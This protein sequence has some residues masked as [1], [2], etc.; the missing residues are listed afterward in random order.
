M[1]DLS[2]KRKALR[3][4]VSSRDGVEVGGFRGDLSLRG[5]LDNAAQAIQNRLLTRKGEI[6]KLGHH[7]YGSELF[8]LIGEPLSWKTQ[9][10][11]ELYVREA[12]LHE[13]RVAEIVAINFPE[14][15]TLEERMSLNMVI[16]VKIHG[17]EEPLQLALNLNLA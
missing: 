7:Q 14:P 2:L 17:H 11:A 12:L 1:K 15:T 6:S 9:A 3:T 8:R 13:E 4:V 10:R 5:G 16:I